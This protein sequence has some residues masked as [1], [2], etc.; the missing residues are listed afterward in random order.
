MDDG[1]VKGRGWTRELGLG[2]AILVVALAIPGLAVLLAGKSPFAA[3]AAMIFYTLG[4]HT[5]F[6]EVVVRAIPLTLM[7]LG[8]AVAFRAGIFNVGGDGQ[9]IV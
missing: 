9:L 4:T 1:A 3:F 8:V 2:I 6:A 7:G 5:G